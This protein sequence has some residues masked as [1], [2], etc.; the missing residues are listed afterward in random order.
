MQLCPAADLPPDDLVL[1][2]RLTSPCPDN[3]MASIGLSAHWQPRLF[4]WHWTTATRRM[5]A[6]RWFLVRL[7]ARARARTLGVGASA[8]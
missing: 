4:S 8:V 2:E 1:T 5:D 3:R 6:C 7:K